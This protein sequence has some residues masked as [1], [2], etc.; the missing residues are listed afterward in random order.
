MAGF[1]GGFAI[2]FVV[3]LVSQ[4]A[5]LRRKASQGLRQPTKN[6]NPYLPYVPI[7]ET[8]EAAE[9]TSKAYGGEL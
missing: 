5:T 1:R 2:T 9:L 7:D 4:M 6:Q 3:N 8:N